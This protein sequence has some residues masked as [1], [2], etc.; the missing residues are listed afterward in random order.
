MPVTVQSAIS[1][2]KEVVTKSSPCSQQLINKGEVA[3][4]KRAK[5]HMSGVAGEKNQEGERVGGS[6]V[7]EK[8]IFHQGPK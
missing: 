5:K 8:A 4:A 7:R 2:G 3:G 6:C 1:S